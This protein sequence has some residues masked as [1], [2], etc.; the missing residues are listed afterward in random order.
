MSHPVKGVDHVFLLVNDLDKSAEQYRRLGFTLSP[1]GLHSKEK[2]T[3]NYTIMF[4]DDYFE[5]LGIVA[6][7]QGNLHQR[8]KLAAHGEG[9]HAIACRIENAEQA[10]RELAT[11]GIQT[12]AVGKFSRPVKLPN[13]SEGVAAFET[14]SFDDKEVPQ[15]MVF[16][17]QHKTRETVWLPELIEHENGANG[18]SAIIVV[19]NDPASTAHA[20]ARLY[21]DGKATAEDGAWRVY[22]GPRS[23]DIVVYE[24]ADAEKLYGAETLKNTSIEAFAGLAIRVADLGKTRSVLDH[25]GVSYVEN[26]GRIIVQP[27]EA[28][29]T[30]LVFAK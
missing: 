3:G 19:S 18:L 24:R 29:G 21:A 23:A 25:N 7:T 12:G 6:Q 17:C 10:K 16:M 26:E 13:G 4:P 1:R 11:L 14:I 8:E 2:G 5:L 30:I 28:S 9:L 27:G 22:T 15:G 20:F